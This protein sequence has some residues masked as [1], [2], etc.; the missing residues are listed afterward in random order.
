MVHERGLLE[1]AYCTE[2]RPFNQGSRLTAFELV[3]D[4]VP[5][6]LIADSAAGISDLFIGL[7]GFPLFLS[8]P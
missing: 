4:G 8:L 6:T 5:A 7:L 3:H 2:T 1:M